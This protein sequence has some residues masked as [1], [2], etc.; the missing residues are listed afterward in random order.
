[1]THQ[2]GVKAGSQLEG[3]LHLQ[4]E[5]LNGTFESQNYIPSFLIYQSSIVHPL[6]SICNMF[7]FQF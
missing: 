2:V 3:N 7:P 6:T 5:V 4:G 1:M